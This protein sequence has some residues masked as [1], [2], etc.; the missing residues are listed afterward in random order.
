MITIIPG[1]QP[2]QISK[3]AGV[4][5]VNPTTVALDE[6]ASFGSEFDISALAAAPAGVYVAASFSRGDSR[7]RD[8]IAQRTSTGAHQSICSWP[9]VGLFYVTPID[10]RLVGIIAGDRDDRLL[11]CHV[12]TGASELRTLPATIG[13]VS[14]PLVA[15][16]GVLYGAASDGVVTRWRGIPGRAPRQPGGAVF[17]LAPGGQ[18]PALDSDADGLPSQWET[19]Y[20][21]DPFDAAGDN[22]PSG[23]PDGD[24]RTNAQ[25]LADGTH[26]RGML[27]RYFAEGATGPFFHTRFDLVNPQ[28]A[29]PAIV[30]VRFLTDTG[31]TV[32]H[33]VIVP[34]SAHV[35]HRSGDDARPR[36]RRRSRPSIEADATVAVDRTMTW[37]AS[38]TAATSR[39]AGRAR[40]RPG[41][42]PKDRRR[43]TS[44][45]STC[46][47]TRRRRPSTATVRYLRPFGQPPIE[48]DLH[49]AA[50]QPDHDRRRLPTGPELA[51]T[52]VSAVITADGADRRRARDVP[53][54][55]AA[56]RSPPGTRAPA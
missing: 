50:A 29:T 5:R 41:T 21:L 54:P 20:R 2:L 46:C 19:T 55:A 1:S 43:A 28:Q 7:L 16:G 39:P 48:T 10:D 26:P 40:R 36:Q 38:A 45:C 32:A 53:E 37:D 47:R 35:S 52:D 17:R 6:V 11:V 23:D 8:P 42:S 3:T 31:A 12:P 4:F 56:S 24:G 15:I 14:A 44:R 30:R 33:D 27:T 18:P 25:E 49:A 51:S 9:T 13:T 22:G 34:P